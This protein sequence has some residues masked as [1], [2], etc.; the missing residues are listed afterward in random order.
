MLFR[1]PASD[2]GGWGGNDEQRLT[3]DNSGYGS[4]QGGFI[5]SGYGS[6]D[7]GFFDGD[8]SFV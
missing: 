7:G 4:D 6:D 5:D 8:D 3:A 1:S 2:S